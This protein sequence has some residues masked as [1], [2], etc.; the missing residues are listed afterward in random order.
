MH[1]RHHC[2]CPL[3]CTGLPLG[4]IAP[5]D[6]RAS[7]GAPHGHPSRARGVGVTHLFGARRALRHGGNRLV[8]LL[9]GISQGRRR[10]PQWRTGLVWNSVSRNQPPSS[11]P[12]EIKFL[13]RGCGISNYHR[14]PPS[15]ARSEFTARAALP[16]EER[17]APPAERVEA[18]VAPP[19][20]RAVERAGD[21][22][23][24]A[25]GPMQNDGTLPL[26]PGALACATSHQPQPLLA[27][28]SSSA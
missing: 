24:A 18:C 21:L 23:A 17:V 16:S 20:E 6:P 25:V 22:R 27:P 12:A 2:A 8:L 5:H 1:H 14:R 19:A 15:F 13:D 4:R 11:V 7:P 9:S 10:P 28:K 26:R 3:A